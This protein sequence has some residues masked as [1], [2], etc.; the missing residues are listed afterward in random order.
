M[1][2]IACGSGRHLAAL[3]ARGFHAV[4]LDLSRHLLRE[5]AAHRPGWLVRGDMRALPFGPD[6]FPVTLSM[7]TS[8][9]YFA[10]SDEDRVML[11][12]A[13]RVVAPDGW[14]VLDYLNAGPTLAGLTRESRRTEGEYEFHELREV[15]SPAGGRRRI[16]KTIQVFQAGRPLDLL[17]EEVAVY[18]PDELEAL[19][20]GAGFRV[21]ERL[22]DYDGAPFQTATSPRLLLLARR[23]AGG[24]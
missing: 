22:G 1:L 15:E 16:V 3:T 21:H 20:V 2:D 5:A 8:F 7:F 12:E 10:T 13:R 9:G 23:P 18:P 14:F 19:V 6:T 4:G 17:R 24:R 11:A